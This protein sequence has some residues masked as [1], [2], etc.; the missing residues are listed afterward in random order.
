MIVDLTPSEDQ[1]MIED[2]I[3]SFLQDRLPVERLRDAVNHGG[4]G[5][6]ALW[7]ELAALGLFGLGSGEEH[8]GMGLGLAEEALAARALGLT[9]ASPTVLAQLAAPHFAS[10]AGLR[11]AIVS[12]SCKVAFANCLG[13]GSAHLIDG[14]AAEQVLLIS[15]QGAALLP[16]SVLGEAKP[17]AGTDETVTLARIDIPGDLPPRGAAADRASL[18]IAAYLTGIAQAA[19]TMAVDYA[20]TR[21]QFGQPIGAFQAI[22]HHCADMATRAA[23]A[24]AQCFFTAVGFTNGLDDGSEV[25][26]GRMLASR[27]A[28]ENAKANIQ[29]HGGMGFTAECDAH[30]FLKRAH[31][32]ALLGSDPAAERRRLLGEVA[33]TN[34]R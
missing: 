7:S 30:L 27:A 15:P 31:L 24:E 25:A 11:A 19:T 14:E 8:G 23:A 21:E 9:L 28:I 17:V 6:R 32:M 18:L 4:A 22:K 20:R 5:E 2:G 29:I 10:D 34:L 33:Y 16:R 3:R 13:D 26:C 1:R 12:G